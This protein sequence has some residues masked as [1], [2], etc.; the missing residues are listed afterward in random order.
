MS[1]VYSVHYTFTYFVP[2]L[3]FAS[4]LRYPGVAVPAK[5][6]IMIQ[7]KKLNETK[8]SRNISICGRNQKQNSLLFNYNIA[9]I[10]K[11][12]NKNLVPLERTNIYMKVVQSTN[13]NTNNFTIYLLAAYLT[14]FRPEFY[15]R[16]QRIL[17]TRIPVW[18]PKQ[19]T[20]KI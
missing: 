1:L 7:K 10:R 11:G 4:A 12:T 5:R 8:L 17:E 3:P 2:M 6:D 16:S 15:G 18:A 19:C 20:Q 14:T 9:E 13:G